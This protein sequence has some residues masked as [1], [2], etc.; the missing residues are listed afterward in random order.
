MEIRVDRKRLADELTL[1]GGIVERRTTIPILSHLRIEAVPDELRLAAT[2]LDVSLATRCEAEV[3]AGGEIAIQARK[4][5]DI[6]R[7]LPDESV[8]LAIDEGTTMEIAGERSRFSLR[9]LEAENFP[10][11]PS[12]DSPVT[13]RIPLPLLKRMISKVLFAVSTEQSRFQLNGA[14]L[15][16]GDEKVE[17]VATD[18]HR[19]ALVEIATESEDGE[20]VPVVEE[21]VGGVLV[22]RKALHEI[23]RF[24]DDVVVN[25]RRSE[26]HVGFE[27][28]DRRLT[29]RILEGT[30]PDYERVIA[31]SHDKKPVLGRGAFHGAVQRVALVTGER[32]RG[33]LLRFSP[34]V[35]EI[36]AANPDLGEARERVPCSYDGE[37]VEIGLNPDY[38]SSF[39]AAVESER[40]RLE[41]K[42]TESQCVGYPED[43][44]AIRH[45]CVIMPMH[46]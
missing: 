8:S 1:L 29:S 23:E 38:L 4:F 33:V 24:D 26:H 45:L 6:I 36:S 14:L 19:L 32:S 28:G 34:E 18:G 15:K 9:G 12:V 46:V 7:S 31:K 22:P 11:L 39:L 21:A 5:T 2:D 27:I 17:M 42:D 37:E 41:V 13:M 43:E 44:D 10:T 40:V 20:D 16:I 3:E 25:Y 35:L 30:F